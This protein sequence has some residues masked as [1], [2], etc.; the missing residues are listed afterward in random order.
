MKLL[1]KAVPGIN[2]MMTYINDMVNGDNGSQ[3]TNQQLG[4]I[5][6]HFR[7]NDPTIDKIVAQGKNYPN[8]AKAKQIWNEIYNEYSKG[9]KERVCKTT[10]FGWFIISF[11]WCSSKL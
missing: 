2:N 7:I 6:G 10:T 4:Q 3:F 11:K 5:I 8:Q 9:D 1:D